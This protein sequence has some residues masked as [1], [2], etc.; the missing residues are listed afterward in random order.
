MKHAGIYSG[1]ALSTTLLAI[2]ISGI[3]SNISFSQEKK[4]ITPYIQLQYFSDNDGQKSLRTTLTYSKNRME[5]PLPGMNIAFYSGEKSKLKIAEIVTDNKGISNLLLADLKG[6]AADAAGKYHF[7]SLFEG[8]DTIESSNSELAVKDISLLME[9]STVDS[10]RKVIL[11]ASAI[12]NGRKIPVKGEVV[13]VYVTRMFSLL[14]LG[15]VTLDDSGSGSL[16]FPSDLPG[17]KEGNLTVIAKIEENPA[18]G[19][20]EKRQNIKWGKIETSKIPSGH[21]ALWTKTA[22]RWMIYT[23]TILLAGVWGHYMYTIIC[24]IR[25]KRAS[26]KPLPIQS[27]KDK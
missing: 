3:T 21:R 11:S 9:L 7:S 17:D 25:I 24:I 16:D 2:L 5:L 8:N 23:L 19:N 26:K 15:E 22:P 18:Y 13:Q 6:I 14:P 12:E 10:T 20:L 1:R 4:K 27:G